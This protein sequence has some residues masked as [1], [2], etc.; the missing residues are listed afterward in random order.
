MLLAMTVLLLSIGAGWVG[1]ASGLKQTEDSL[2]SFSRHDLGHIVNARQSLLSYAA[3]Y[4]FLYGPMGAGAG[5]L[6]CPDTDGNQQDSVDSQ[7][8]NSQRLDG[9]NP[10]CASLGGSDGSLPRHTVLPGQR[11]LF[12][13]EPYQRYQYRVSAK[14]INNPVNRRINLQRLI[15]SSSES[16]ATIYLPSSVDSRVDAHV[17]IT[18]GALI[19]ATSAS[20]AA[21]LLRRHAQ[22]H[23]EQCLSQ[24]DELITT[25]VVTEDLSKAACP[26]AFIPICQ[27]DDVMALVLD[28]P[29]V[30][31]DGCIAD[32]LAS[33]TIEGVPALRHWFVRNEWYLSIALSRDEQCD[34][35]RAAA[36]SCVLSYVPQSGAAVNPLAEFIELRWERQL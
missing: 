12:H 32:S 19:H 11:Y 35:S 29:L 28:M 20:V 13:S 17:S 24:S 14:V 8:A 5:H 9:P 15:T 34:Q 16:L 30:M 22:I 18:G 10:P 2:T 27:G 31:G 26:T 7:S 25:L 4:P 1:V 23:A 36:L 6:P 3:V 21:W 33:N